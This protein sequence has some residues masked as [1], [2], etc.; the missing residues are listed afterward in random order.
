[1]H[2]RSVVL[3]T[4][5][6]I[7]LLACSA[8]AWASGGS[9]TASG[10]GES[11]VLPKDRNN[12]AS[13]VAAYDAAKRASV[14]GAISEAHEY[15]A[16]YAKSVGL[17]LGAVTSVSDQRQSGFFGY[18]GPGNTGGY[19][20]PGQFCGTIRQPIIV[21]SNHRF[22]IKGFKVHHRCFVPR[23]AYTTLTVTYSAS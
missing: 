14:G 1:M 3:A 19:F 22:R 16:L 15:A 21:R 4:V 11:R 5:C 10:T 23:F 20:G 2:R 9:I 18:G 6:A 12:N 17:T 8:P 13:I 7:A